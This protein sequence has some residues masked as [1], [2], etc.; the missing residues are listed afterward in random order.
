VLLAAYDSRRPTRD[1]DLRGHGI[2]N[3][4]DQVLAIMQA[5]ARLHVDD[6]L[7]FDAARATA[8]GIRDGDLYGGL[9][10]TAPAPK[11]RPATASPTSRRA[12]K[13]SRSRGDSKP[14]PPID[15]PSTSHLQHA[16]A[17]VPGTT[18]NTAGRAGPPG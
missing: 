7:L 14:R 12:Q 13:P 4:T 1:I 10:L 6:G 18:A 8:E 3:D 11:S 17:R 15:Q 2:S 9:S 5:I 16:T